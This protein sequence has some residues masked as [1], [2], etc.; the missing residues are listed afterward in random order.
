L[1]SFLYDQELTYTVNNPDGRAL[2]LSRV[3]TI[4][5]QERD[6]QRTTG[7]IQPPDALPPRDETW[8]MWFATAA[9]AKEDLGKHK[10][11]PELH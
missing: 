10:Q 4:D 7:V 8:P 1:V 2:F 11:I 3:V 6:H 5:G 9:G